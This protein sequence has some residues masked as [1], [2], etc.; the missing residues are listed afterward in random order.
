MSAN[1][2]AKSENKNPITAKVFWKSVWYGIIVGIF[3]GWVKMGW[4]NLF[5]PRTPARNAINPPQHMAQQLG[6]P[7]DLIFGTVTYNGN[8]IMPF[9]L[10]LHFTFAI[11]FS[12]LFILLIQNWKQVSMGQ[13]VVYGLVLWVLWHIILMP[14]FGTTPAP[15]DRPF[16]EHFSECLGHAVWGWSIAIVAYYLIA[17]QKVKTLVNF[18][19]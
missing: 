4:E 16:E 17:H 13:G 11:V 10:L 18:D 12:F 19:K 5:P 6:F 14:L 1:T 7:D 3:S 15:W 8:Q 2:P 9:T